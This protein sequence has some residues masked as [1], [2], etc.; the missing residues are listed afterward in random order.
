MAVAHGCVCHRGHPRG[1]M[2]LH[3]GSIIYCKLKSQGSIAL[4]S[5]EMI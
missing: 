3:A 1:D 2:I 5:K 4:L